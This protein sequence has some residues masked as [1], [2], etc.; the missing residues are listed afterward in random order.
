MSQNKIERMKLMIV[1]TDINI[2]KLKILMWNRKKNIP[3][4]R[5]RLSDTNL[6]DVKSVETI[7][8]MP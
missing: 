2:F 5:G 6:V 3:S 8:I 4:Q 7:Q 1:S